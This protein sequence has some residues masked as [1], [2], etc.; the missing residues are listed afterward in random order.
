M[1]TGV[2]DNIIWHVQ[3]EENVALSHPVYQFLWKE[4]NWMNWKEDYLT[5]Y[6]N[7]LDS[8]DESIYDINAPTNRRMI[9]A[10]TRVNNRSEMFK[11]YYW[12]DIDRD[13]NP[14]HIWSICPLSNEPLK[15]LPVDTHRNNRKVSP[16]IPLI[17]PAGR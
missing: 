2:D 3:T 15:D 11:I 9:D 8:D 10:I 5:A 13:K 14:N 4:I 7:W 6:H 12:F 1:V 16:S 17:F